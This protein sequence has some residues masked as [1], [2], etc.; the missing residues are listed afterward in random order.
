MKG[1][2][3]QLPAVRVSIH[4]A[5]CTVRSAQCARCGVSWHQCVWCIYGL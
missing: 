3:V 2:K 4:G 1:Q 5:V